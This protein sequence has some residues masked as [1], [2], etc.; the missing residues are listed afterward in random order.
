MA[1]ALALCLPAQAATAQ[2][3]L[4][5]GQPV[6]P[7]P[8]KGMPVRYRIDAPSGS[9]LAGRIEA[10]TVPVTADLLDGQGRHLRRLA[11]AGRGD[12]DFQAMTE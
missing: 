5:P 7:V 8:S 4:P 9:Y 6:H 11:E 3:V 2:P 10:G 1:W 12:I